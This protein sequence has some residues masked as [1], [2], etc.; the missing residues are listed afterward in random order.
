M[1]VSS[2]I[3][4]SYENTDKAHDPFLLPPTIQT[5]TVEDIHFSER[6]TSEQRQTFETLCDT[7]SDIL[8]DLPCTTN[9]VNHRITVTS[10]DPVRVKQYPIPFHTQNVIKAEV[11]KMLQLKVI[12]PSSSPYSS[13]VVIARKREGTNRFCID[14]RKLNNITVFDAEPMQNPDSIFS[15]IIGQKFVSKIDLSKGY[16][17]VPM[18]EDSKPMTTS[19][20]PTGLYHFEQCHL[21]L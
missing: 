14:F 8:T 19:S 5:E 9:L 17:Q 2:L 15:K 7:F 16:W 18:E 12:E 3:D 10:S 6:L 11:E 21:V 4:F 20:T 13:P 1:C